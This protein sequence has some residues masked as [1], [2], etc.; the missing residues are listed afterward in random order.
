MM[1]FMPNDAHPMAEMNEQITNEIL[2]MI[3]LS[4]NMDNQI[5]TRK[6]SLTHLTSD[7]FV[8]N[9][10]SYIVEIGHGASLITPTLENDCGNTGRS[11]IDLVIRRKKKKSPSVFHRF[12]RVSA[13]RTIDE[14]CI[15]ISTGI[16]GDATS[17]A[18]RS[19]HGVVISKRTAAIVAADP[20]AAGEI[21]PAAGYI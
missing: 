18:A 14:P 13:R 21:S 20:H 9:C 5:V 6:G 3:L 12:E 17:S 8:T 10:I 7:R 15:V 19:D 1:R 11:R 2:S 4:R 16:V